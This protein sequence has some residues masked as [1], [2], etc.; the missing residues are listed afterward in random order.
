MP[1]DLSTL[2]KPRSLE[3]ERISSLGQRGVYGYPRAA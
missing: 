1:S 2:Q 3:E